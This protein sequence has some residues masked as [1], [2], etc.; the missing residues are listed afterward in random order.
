MVIEQFYV[1][2]EIKVTYIVVVSMVKRHSMLEASTQGRIINAITSSTNTKKNA[3]LPILPKKRFRTSSSKL[4]MSRWKNRIIQ[5]SYE[6]IELFS[7]TTQI[8]EDLLRIDDELTISSEMVTKFV[9][10][11]SKTDIR[12][13]EYNRKYEELTLRYERLQIKQ[14]ELLRL[15]SEKQGQSLKK[16]SFISSLNQTD[17]H[18]NDWNANISMLLVDSAEIH[19]DS[20]ITFRLHNGEE[21]TVI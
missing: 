15:R 16:K 5:D 1:L 7:D 20:S 12:L 8:D 13:E 19:R 10:E 3:K 4:I 2:K 6:V 11:N 9:K 21:T 17:N 18:L 14:E